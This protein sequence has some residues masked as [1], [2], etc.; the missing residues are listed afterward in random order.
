MAIESSSFLLIVIAEVML[1][2]GAICTFLLFRNKK[3]RHLL[4]QLQERMEQLI[5]DLR[6]ARSSRQNSESPESSYTE[7][8]NEYLRSTKE[9]HGTLESPQDIALD[10]DPS[11]PI[12][13]RAAALRYAMLIAEKEATAEGDTNWTLLNTKYEQLFSYT[14]EY[15]EDG[16]LAEEVEALHEE[17]TAAKKRINNLEKFKALYFDLEEQWQTSKDKAQIHYDELTAM[18][19]LTEDSDAFEAALQNY[20]SAYNDVGKLITGGVGDTT[21]IT[22]QGDNKGNPDAH[23]EIRH[24]R[25]VAADQHRII[26]ELQKKLAEATSDEAKTN[27]INDLKGELDKQARFVQ[28]SETCVK[29]MEDELNNANKEMEQL[30]SRLN[31][32]PQIKASIKEMRET[33]EEQEQTI[34]SLK[35]E[36]KRLNSKMQMSLKDNEETSSNETR[37]LKQEITKLQAKYADLEE[38]YLD[39]KLQEG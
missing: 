10:L 38:R 28:E 35:A 21:I 36:N 7:Q 16:N 18:A 30:R 6:S 1:L 11:V 27:V 3:L 17:L 29:L 13:R 2:L 39:L 34:F 33:N 32:L 37:K 8:L 23:G 25:N 4:K 24:L 31:Q 26:T 12:T 20:Q 22:V 15:Q 5:S 14:E 9:Y 19:P